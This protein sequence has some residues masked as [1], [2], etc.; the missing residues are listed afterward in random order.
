VEEETEQFLGLQ[1]LVAEAEEMAE[2]VAP[3]S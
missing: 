2:Q 1:I 3:V